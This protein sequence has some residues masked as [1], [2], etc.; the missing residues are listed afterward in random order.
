[1]P[2]QGIS[3]ANRDLRQSEPGA[4]GHR[5]AL[6]AASLSFCRPTSRASDESTCCCCRCHLRGL[7]GSEAPF[8]TF[9]SRSG[10]TDPNHAR[11][12]RRRPLHIQSAQGLPAWHQI[13]VQKVCSWEATAANSAQCKTWAGG[14]WAHHGLGQH[15]PS[16]H[17]LEIGHE[18]TGLTGDN[19]DTTFC[20]TTTVES[21]RNASE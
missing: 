2:W 4:R 21:S 20:T 17:H 18:F 14:K 6:E 1:M 8:S 13:P 15:P 19:A 3:D 12:H 16:P 7:R 10:S 9:A 11:S 5:K